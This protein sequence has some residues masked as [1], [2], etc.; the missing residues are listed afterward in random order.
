MMKDEE[1]ESSE[2]IVAR[3]EKARELQF[4]RF[5]QSKTNSEMNVVELKKYCK[6]GPEQQELLRNAMKQYALSGRGAHR[7]LKI[8][9]TIP[10]SN[11][12]LPSCQPKKLRRVSPTRKQA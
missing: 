1:A 10:A 11:P 12:I 9:S 6:L 8:A 4:K 7:L 5:G 3:V 2:K